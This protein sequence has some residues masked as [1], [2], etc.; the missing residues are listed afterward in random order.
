[1]QF[2]D[3]IFLISGEP[4]IVNPE[5][6]LISIRTPSPIKC[7]LRPPLFS[8][9]GEQTGLKRAVAIPLTDYTVEIKLSSTQERITDV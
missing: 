1:M 2:Q 8:Q 7:F 5:I 4:L 9:T 6:L 3:L